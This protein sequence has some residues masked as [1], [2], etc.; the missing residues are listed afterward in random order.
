MDR[1]KSYQQIVKA[2]LTQYAGHKDHFIEDENVEES[3]TQIVFDDQRNHYFLLDI[4]WS[5]MD[6]IH[7]C[8]LHLDIK[9][10]KIWIQKDYVEAGIAEDLIEHGVPK[11][12]IVL[13]FQA[14]Y[15]R[16]FTEFAAS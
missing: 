14:P 2:I 8:L 6:R 1:L 12:D 13:G 7:V 11:E 9:D 3:E 16:P 10:G 4:G 5:H 15:K